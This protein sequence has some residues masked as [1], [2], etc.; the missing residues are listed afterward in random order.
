M[1]R[2]SQQLAKILTTTFAPA[3]FSFDRAL[4]NPTII[5]QENE[6]EGPSKAI[7]PFTGIPT[8][9]PAPGDP[10]P[11][12]TPSASP[13][14]AKFDWV[15]YNCSPAINAVYGVSGGGMPPTVHIVAPMGGA[16]TPG[17]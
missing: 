5:K 17:I 13:E 9:E 2:C 14:P 12:P 10:N 6:E 7:V 15:F 16:N 11:A 8:P 3:K 4:K 1:S